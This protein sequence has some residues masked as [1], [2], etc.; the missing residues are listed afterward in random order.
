[1]R[2]ISHSDT[3][4]RMRLSSSVCI[5]D[6]TGAPYANMQQYTFI[7]EYY[8]SVMVTTTSTTLESIK[9]LGSRL[10]DDDHERSLP[11]KRRIGT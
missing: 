3:V 11:S 7:I 9:G 10:R 2:A 4:S 1:M 8:I 6:A 5:F